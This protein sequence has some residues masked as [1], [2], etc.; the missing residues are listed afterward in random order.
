[1]KYLFVHQ[2]MPGQYK[3][4]CQRLAADKDNTVVFIT[5]REGIEL[6]GVTKVLS[7]SATAF[8]AMTCIKGP[9]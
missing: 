9:P 6:P 8:A 5:K 7:F 2:N 4:I 3:H 1:M